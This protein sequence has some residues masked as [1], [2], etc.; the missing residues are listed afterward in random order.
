MEVSLLITYIK[1]LLN[2]MYACYYA[3]RKVGEGTKTESA[4]LVC[5]STTHFAEG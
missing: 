1:L 5:R 4:F 3:K 2:K